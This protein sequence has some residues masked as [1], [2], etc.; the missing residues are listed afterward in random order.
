MLRPTSD[1]DVE[2]VVVTGSRLKRDT[3]TSIAPLQVISGQVSRNLGAVDPGTIMQDSSAVC[4]SP[5]ST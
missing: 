2:E 5:D 1:D 4:R 3:Y